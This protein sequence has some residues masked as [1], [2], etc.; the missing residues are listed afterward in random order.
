M[1]LTRLAEEL[2]DR[3]AVV[4]GGS[5][6]T[7]TYAELERQSNQVAHVLADLGLGFG[8]HIAL[9]VENQI[10]V[11]PVVWAAQR[12]GLYYTPVNWHLTVDEAAY[13]VDNC[14]ATVLVF[15]PGLA[16]LAAEVSRR[17]SRTVRLMRLGEEV[18][19]AVG[20]VAG[21][22]ATPLAAEI[23]GYPMFYS[24][25]TTGRPK[26]IL[27]ELLG[28]PFGTGLQA[29]GLMGTAFGL[30]PGSVYLS[31][32]P[33]YH[34][35]PLGWS[36]GT[37]RHGGT[38]VVMER[39]DAAESLRL[40]ERYAVTHAQFVPTMFVRMLKLPEAERT[41]YAVDSLQVVIHAAAPC[42]VEVKRQM[43][44][45]FGPKLV[46]YYAG[47][48]GTG[49]FMIDSASWLAHPGSVGRALLGS[50]HICDDAGR[51]LPVGEIGTVWFSD[52]TR[53]SY[54]DD[55]VKTAGAWNERG[56]TTLGDLG[57]LD[58][59]GFLYL[60]DRRTDLILS[61]GVNIY[62]REVEDVLVMHPSVADVAVVGVPDGEFGQRVHA[63]VKPADPDADIRA[64][65]GVLSSYSRDHLAGF[66]VPRG[67]TFIDEFP[68]LP[69]GKLL[70]RMLPHP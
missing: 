54:H 33:L 11:F 64:L 53:F 4:Q 8:D 61:G 56:W 46:E 50:P 67:F 34:A 25:G 66:K 41:S 48:E 40:I 57:H 23:E 49:F 14:E 63:Y 42:P 37:M 2:G 10:E 22:P 15:S 30:G 52:T 16:A 36:L 69:S 51:E 68:R 60:A 44:D 12:S 7:L 3:P 39:F 1:H 5:G 45:W 62:P 28:T 29:D 19:G 21:A 70:R 26:G 6:A 55:P 59:E 20:F 32:G 38:V 24:S 9:L 13:I 18:E 31:P 17:S 27:P 65:E 47:S 43:I 58:I 35:A